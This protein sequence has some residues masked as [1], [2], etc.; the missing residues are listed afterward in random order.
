METGL[1]DAMTTFV[2]EG[3]VGAPAPRP[4]LVVALADA[5]PQARA[6][7]VTLALACAAQGLEDMLA[8]G[9]D[10]AQALYRLATLVAV[11]T[12]VLEVQDQARQGPIMA[13]HLLAHW[14]GDPFFRR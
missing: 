1:D 8:D 10:Q 6:L 7:Q 14:R 3:L 2:I 11:D 9:L 13:V 12:L 5:F 4:G